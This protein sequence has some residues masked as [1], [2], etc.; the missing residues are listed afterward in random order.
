MSEWSW[1]QAVAERILRI[2]NQLATVAFTISEVWA[3]R[4]EFAQLFPRNRNLREKVRQTLQRLRNDGF[5]F[6]RG[7]GN[8]VLNDG[9]DEL[10]D[11]P[12]LSLPTG[13]DIPQTKVVVRRLRLRCTLLAANIKRRY[14][15]VCQVCRAL[16]VLYAGVNYAEGHHLMPLGARHIFGPDV[17][18][19]ILVLCPNHHI[20]FDRG[21][22]DNHSWELF[23]S[24]RG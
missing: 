22:I 9:F 20:M 13:I 17:P 3:F 14:N 11:E 15:S 6:F 5:L 1:K 8:Y 4:E 24:A 10:E 2:V 19:N 12:I 16:L 21:R 18:G 7:G 23:S